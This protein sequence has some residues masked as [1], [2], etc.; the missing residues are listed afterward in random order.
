MFKSN[1]NFFFKLVKT[2]FRSDKLYECFYCPPQR[3]LFNLQK[4]QS[5]YRTWVPNKFTNATLN[6]F[7]FNRKCHSSK[8]SFFQQ[9]IRTKSLPAALVQSSS[10]KIKPYLKLVRLDKPSGN[11][12]STFLFLFFM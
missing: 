11:L 7:D 5:H 9:L 2:N 8:E 4:V 6:T 10:E 1:K 12:I 3:C